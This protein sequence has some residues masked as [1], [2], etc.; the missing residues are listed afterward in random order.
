[1]LIGG[2]ISYTL[3]MRLLLAIYLI[4]CAL[5]ASPTLY[6]PTGLIE[7]PTAET[8]AYKQFSAGL[9]YM[10]GSSITGGRNDDFFYKFNLGSFETWE[11]GVLGGTF[12]DEGMFVNLKYFLVT[13]DSEDPLFM[14]AGVER[15]GSNTDL[16]PYLV[17]SKRFAEGLNV[18]LGFK[19]FVQDEFVAGAML[20]TEFFMNEQVALLAEVIGE[21]SQ[22]YVVNI[23]ARYY[24][25]N[26]VSLRLFMIDLTK[27]RASSETQFVLGV[28]INRYM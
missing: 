6:G 11:L 27:N 14:S 2:I 23:G 13:N 28:S 25:E 4:G 17:A 7:M 18:H 9:D 5:Y 24:L 3:R 8:I 19:A 15:L 1:M 26:G 21:K 12:L 20:G 22:R 10:I 16:A